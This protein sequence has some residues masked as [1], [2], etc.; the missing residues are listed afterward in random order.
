[1]ERTN[2]T[3]ICGPCHNEFHSKGASTA[4]VLEW[5]NMIQDYLE[6]IGGWDEYNNPG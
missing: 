5:K 1:M 3:P 2:R 4:L 6:R